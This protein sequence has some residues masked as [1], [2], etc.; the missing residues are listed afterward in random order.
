MRLVNYDI[1]VSTVKEM[2]ET[3]QGRGYET[4]TAGLFRILAD[5]SLRANRVSR[6]AMKRLLKRYA[7][8]S[9]MILDDRKD[10]DTPRTNE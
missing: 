1:K 8:L 5:E 4:M 2:E 7:F 6:C 10:D 3:T 9:T